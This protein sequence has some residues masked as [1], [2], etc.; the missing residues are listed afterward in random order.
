MSHAPGGAG[1]P[2]VEHLGF[3]DEATYKGYYVARLSPRVAVL[4]YPLSGG[5]YAA[6]F[7]LPDG[8]ISDLYTTYVNHVMRVARGEGRQRKYK[9]LSGIPDQLTLKCLLLEALPAVEKHY[10]DCYF[11][12]DAAAGTSV[13]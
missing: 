8:P 2:F 1:P 11:D 3:E 13:E 5:Y 10:E 9:N 4:A 6:F 12:L 7:P